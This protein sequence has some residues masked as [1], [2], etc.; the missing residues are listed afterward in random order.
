L[1]SQLAPKR[2]LIRNGNLDKVEGV[3]YSFW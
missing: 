1:N 3:Q 2:Q